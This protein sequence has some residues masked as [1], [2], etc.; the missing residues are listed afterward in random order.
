M[1]LAESSDVHSESSPFDTLRGGIG[2]QRM[3]KFTLKKTNLFD[4]LE[5]EYNIPTAISSI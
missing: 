3:P 5:N 2:D 4:D 1:K